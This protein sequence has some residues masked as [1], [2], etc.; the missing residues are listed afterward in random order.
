MGVN[1]KKNRFN[2]LFLG[3]IVLVL[4]GVCSAWLFDNSVFASKSGSSGSG[5]SGDTCTSDD[6]KDPYY[7]VYP[8]MSKTPNIGG[9]SWHIF[10]TYDDVWKGYK[11]Y[12]TKS[13][14]RIASPQYCIKI[15]DQ[16]KTKSCSTLNAFS[17]GGYDKALSVNCPKSQ[18]NYYL[19]LVFDG[20]TDGDRS[21]LR[22]WGPLAAGATYYSTTAKKDLLFHRSKTAN[23]YNALDTSSV[24]AGIANGSIA[25]GTRVLDAVA[26]RYCKILDSGPC[27]S[28]SKGTLPADV[29][30]I[31]VRNKVTVKLTANAVKTNGTVLKNNCSSDSKEVNQGSAASLTVKNSN[32]GT[33]GYTFS[34]WRN[35]ATSGALTS[36][37]TYTRSITSNTTVYAVYAQNE[38]QGQSIVSRTKDGTALATAGYSATTDSKKGYIYNCDPVNG[39]EVYFRHN[40][41]L[42][43][44]SGATNYS[45][46]RTS[47][48]TKRDDNNRGIDN[49][50]N[51][52]S[53][54]YGES[55]SGKQVS[56]SG[57][58]K[59]YPGMRLCERLIFKSHNTRNS[60]DVYTEVCAY[61]L[62]DA[63]P[64][65]PGQPNNPGGTPDDKE[66]PDTNSGDKSFINIKVRNSSVTKKYNEYQRLVYAK[67]NDVLMYRATY[68]PNLQYTYNLHPSQIQIITS[69]S[70][71]SSINNTDNSKLGVL[72][73]AKKGSLEKWD[74]G[75]AIQRKKVESDNVNY[76]TDSNIAAYQYNQGDTSRKQPDPH[77]VTVDM[78]DVGKS[79][80][81]RAITSISGNPDTRTTPGQV[82]FVEDN[83]GKIDTRSR[84]QIAK[85]RVPYNF[86]TKT[87]VIGKVDNSGDPDVVYAGEEATIAYSIDIDGRKNCLTTDNC[88]EEEAYATKVN[89]ARRELVIYDPA[90]VPE[91]GGGIVSGDRSADICQSYF[92]HVADMINCGYSADITENLNP[93]SNSIKSSFLNQDKS[94]GSRVCV[95]A[96]VFPANSG[97]EN[98][99]NDTQYSK[100][101]RISNSMCFTIAKRPSLQVWG[102]NIYSRGKVTTGTSTK[103]NLAGY[104]E[105]KIEGKD[106]PH[107][108]GSFGELGLIASGSVK[109]LASGAATGYAGIDANGVLSPDPFSSNNT[110]AMAPGGGVKSSICNRSPLTFSNTPCS[111]GTVGELGKTATTSNVENDKTRVLEKLVRE[112]EEGQHTAASPVILNNP[113]YKQSSGIYYY[114]NDNDLEIG[115]G[116][117]LSVD[118]PMPIDNSTVQVVHSENTILVKDNIAY[119]GTYSKYSDL[120]KLVIYGKNVVIDCRVTRI[121]ALI[122]ADEKVVACN[123]YSKNI[124]T[125]SD[126]DFKDD[127]KNHI[128]EAANSNPLKVNGAIV[129]K[130]LISNRTYGAASGV[131]SI[132]PAEIINFDPT[133]YMW[134]NLGDDDGNDNGELEVTLTKELAP[135]R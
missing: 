91:K 14:S 135:R 52:T 117:H 75:F 36:G 46:A 35:N 28:Y 87:E 101:W 16:E 59:L 83:L 99:W 69:N 110:S 121:D 25:S 106:N 56:N 30:Y 92:G 90:V 128:N 9:S 79:I 82:T 57:P 85:A 7:H 60:P 41:K 20:W 10:S 112:L 61:A 37:N 1:M 32:C 51:V 84:Y 88:S 24:N 42:A 29:G 2:Y 65:D 119:N 98:N 132:I 68:W 67:P 31:C 22:Y 89:D 11:L 109:G 47:N 95:A 19:A 94:A 5:S 86:E 53:G 62:G 133:L 77:S 39:C 3:A 126:A 40:I 21:K 23:T 44:G 49:N 96:A 58:F 73:D 125:T 13:W 8:D 70:N 27:A 134:G 105:Y 72:F 124:N 80:N 123:N 118:N 108:F 4:I 131:N 66:N 100:T 103:Y 48:M 81:E 63:Q 43:S 64:G 130:T 18:Y 111:S 113:E 50:N 55:G 15:D 115:D 76:D 33:T 34:G 129:A 74:N 12:N 93:G 127:I 104:G 114:Y 102:G 6:C 71:G 78:N 122:V 97:A 120:P 45:V 54:S 38:W 107:V 26:K 116:T 17:D